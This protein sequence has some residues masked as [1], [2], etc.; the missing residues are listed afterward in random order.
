MCFTVGKREVANVFVVNSKF[1]RDQLDELHLVHTEF[2]WFFEDLY[3][4]DG[5]PGGRGKPDS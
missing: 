3:I 4:S 5:L 1:S 2:V